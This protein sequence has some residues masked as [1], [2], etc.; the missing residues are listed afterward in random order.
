M[1]FEGTQLLFQLLFLHSQFPSNTAA[2]NN[3][4]KYSWILW[5]RNTEMV[6]KGQRID[7]SWCLRSQELKATGAAGELMAEC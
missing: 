7:V 6:Q 3:H 1:D 2:K 5:I 4:V